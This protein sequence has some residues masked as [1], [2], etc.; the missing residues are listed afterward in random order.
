MDLFYRFETNPYR[1]Y[2]PPTPKEVG[3][4]LAAFAGRVAF[5]MVESLPF[6]KG[7]LAERFL[8]L[9]TAQSLWT[10]ALIFA[11]WLMA[12]VIGG[13]LGLAINAIL[14]V[15]GLHSLWAQ[16]GEITGDLK[17]WLMNAYEAR[18][19]ADLRQAGAFFASALASGGITFLELVLAH[20]VFKIAEVTLRKRFP[21]P[22]TLEAEFEAGKRRRLASLKEAKEAAKRAA[23]LAKEAAR[24]QGLTK[25]AEKIAP[26]F[27][28]TEV[29]VAGGVVAL[30][31]G[32]AIVVSSSG[33][34]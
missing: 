1:G 22:K 19:D 33:G 9:F 29:L 34:K 4:H 23:E 10:M 25:G 12:T 3:Q 30:S 6:M 32:I 13:V 14:I 7:D 31:A 24:N 27:P 17:A 28:T 11:G 15:Y 18:N 16:L 8:G 2:G 26:M 5:S 20:K 21:S